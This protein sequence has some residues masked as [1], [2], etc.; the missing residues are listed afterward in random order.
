MPSAESISDLLALLYEAAASPGHWP[1]FFE[2]LR[3]SANADSAFF[4]LV[5][6]EDHCNFSLTHGFDP[7]YQ[8]AYA[9]HLYIHDVVY[10]R[11]V[12]LKRIHGHWAGTLQSVMPEKDYLRSVIFNE[13]S[14]PQ[15]FRHQCAAALGGLDGGLEG[16]IG[17]HRRAQKEPFSQETVA[18]LAMLV[19]H[20]KRALN[21]H[22]TMNHLRVHNAELKHS[23][24]SLDL[25]ILSIDADG[26]V[27]RFTEAANTILEARDGLQVDRGFLRAEVSSERSRLSKIMAG[28]VATGRGKGAEC[29]VRRNT[30]AS[31]QAGNGVLWTPGPG[32]AMLISRRPPKRPLQ[33]VVT[34]FRSSEILLDER[35][36]A[37]IFLSDPD[38]RPSPRSAVLRELYGLT[39]TESRLAD[40]LAQGYEL[41]SAADQLSMAFETARSHLKVIFSKTGASRQTDLVRLILG[42]PGS[43]L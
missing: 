12:A 2:A 37:L 40:L 25:P 14:G 27:L 21:T 43:R 35:P 7:A 13:F 3:H 32:G 22:R 36:A 38:G 9:D 30:T 24:D 10:E 8:R 23:I 18:L 6:P 39:R 20:L 17:M 15:G 31:P 42:L 1:N 33:L 19:P 34:P 26:R 16:G 11:Y 5:D 28:A 4:I 41:A 29:A